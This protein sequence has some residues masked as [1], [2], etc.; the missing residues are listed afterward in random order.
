M[1]GSDSDKR[2]IVKKG[3][4]YDY[5]SFKEFLNNFDCLKKLIPGDS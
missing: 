2:V 5:S 1:N 3:R 4:K